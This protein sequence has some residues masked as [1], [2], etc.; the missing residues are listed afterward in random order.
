MGGVCNLPEANV[1]CNPKPT[2]ALTKPLNSGVDKP[3]SQRCDWVP[4]QL[5]F[6]VET[7]LETYGVPRAENG[8]KRTGGWELSRGMTC[9]FEALWYNPFNQT[10]S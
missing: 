3:S 2:Y 6:S 10:F 5:M 7:F 9:C 1:P 8:S 4:M